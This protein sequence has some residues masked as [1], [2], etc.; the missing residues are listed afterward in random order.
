MDEDGIE[1]LVASKD[2]KRTKE[3]IKQSVKLFVDY[4]VS[5]IPQILV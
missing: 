4:L 1:D 5:L 2:S 3:A